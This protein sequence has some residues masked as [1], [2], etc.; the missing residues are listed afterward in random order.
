MPIHGDGSPTAELFD[1]GGVAS[2]P[3]SNNS[4]RPRK[5]RRPSAWRLTPISRPPAARRLIALATPSR[6][7]HTSETPANV[8]PATRFVVAVSST[9]RASE[10]RLAVRV[11]LRTPAM[12]QIKSAHQ[13]GWM[14][15]DHHARL[16]SL[17]KPRGVR[18]RRDH[19]RMPVVRHGLPRS[20]VELCDPR[21]AGHGRPLSGT[22]R[23]A[24]CSHADHSSPTS[25]QRKRCRG[26]STCTGSSTPRIRNTD[27]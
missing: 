14:N 8:R 2:R 5:P 22:A 18:R 20:S 4:V 27:F 16:R 24:A 25:R 23:G 19:D 6:P 9:A 21:G 17:A 1:L 3:G 11:A 10:V 15:P 13:P 7:A 26:L 12:M